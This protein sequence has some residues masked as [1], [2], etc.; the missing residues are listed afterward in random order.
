MEN[1]NDNKS[2]VKE[3]QNIFLKIKN[4]ILSLFRSRKKNI[5]END[6]LENI[7]EKIKELNNKKEFYDTLKTTINDEKDAFILQRKYENGDLKV[8]EMS[9]E[10]Y[11]KIQD[12]YYKQIEDL[13]NQIKY[14]KA[15]LSDN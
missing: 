4:I 11:A 3:K 2:L 10:Q 15:K 7:N 6:R 8:N 9:K 12:L 5:R 1:K 13:T 14:K